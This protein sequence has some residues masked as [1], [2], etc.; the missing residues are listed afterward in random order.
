MGEGWPPSAPFEMIWKVTL[1]VAIPLFIKKSL[2][3]SQCIPTTKNNQP[4]SSV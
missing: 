3:S 4:K 2:K 1:P